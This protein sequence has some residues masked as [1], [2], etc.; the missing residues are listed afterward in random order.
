MLA[1]EVD[2][3][4]VG[5]VVAVFVGMLGIGGLLFG[6]GLSKVVRLGELV[7]TLTADVSSLSIE[8]RDLKR[9]VSG[10]EDRERGA[11][12]ASDP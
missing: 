5:A 6:W 8:I 2:G 10:L 3:A 4:V 12:R 1:I 7:A 9:A 11:K